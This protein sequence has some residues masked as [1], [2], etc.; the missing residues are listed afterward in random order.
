MSDDTRTDKDSGV[1]PLTSKNQDFEAYETRK[2]VQFLY[3]IKETVFYFRH[4]L[5]KTL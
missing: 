2:Y 3:S 1:H 5:C 4:F